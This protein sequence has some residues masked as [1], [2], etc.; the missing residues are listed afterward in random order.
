MKNLPIILKSELNILEK[1]KKGTLILDR[2]DYSKF[3]IETRP[4]GLTAIPKINGATN[5]TMYEI[6]YVFKHSFSPTRGNVSGS[7]YYKIIDIES[8]K[9]DLGIDNSDIAEM[10]DYK[11]ANSFATSTAYKRILNGLVSFY[12]LIKENGQQ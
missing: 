12:T 2:N 7:V 3:G 4:F 10:F 1:S 5:E 9:K 11:N 6:K 8:I